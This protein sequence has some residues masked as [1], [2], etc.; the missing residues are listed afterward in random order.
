METKTNNFIEVSYKLYT[1]ENGEK[2]L[3]EEATAEQPFQFI[4][5]MGT[6]LEAFEKEVAGLDKE[7]AFDFTLSQDDAYGDYET[8]R[9]VD[10][11][12]E[13]FTLNGHFDHDNVYVDAVI[14]LQNEDGNRFYGR[15][16]SIGEEQVKIDLN[17]PLAGKVLNFV[18][19][20]VEKREA[21]NEELQA[22]IAQMSGGCGCSC[23]ED[24]EEG[25]NGC[26]ESCGCGGC[27]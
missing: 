4:S 27:H 1:I 11:N 6:T 14:P 3:V 18:G 15:V 22:L 26:G 2:E 16:L 12:K 5:G 25:G 7:Q 13:I 10:V 9:V 19:Q 23:G 24:N 21:T 17:H 8:E 20:V